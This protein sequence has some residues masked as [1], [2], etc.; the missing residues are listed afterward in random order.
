ML[1]A[2]S[3]LLDANVRAGSVRADLDPATVL[4]ALGGLLHLSPDADWR[5]QAKSLTDLLWTGMS[6]GKAGG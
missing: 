4:R 1:S 3:T 2:V 5:S 6:T